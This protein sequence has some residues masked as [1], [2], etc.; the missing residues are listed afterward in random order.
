M[1]LWVYEEASKVDET[2]V[3]VSKNSPRTRDLCLKEGIEIIKTPGDGYVEDVRFILSEYGDFISSVADVPF[4]KASDFYELKK[5]F[6]GRSLTGVLP[7]SRIPKDLRPLTYKGYAIVGLN[8]VSWEGEEL[9]I[10]SNPLLALNVN[11]PKDLELARKIAKMIGR[12]DF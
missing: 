4:V 3:A 8:A 11:T 12:K 7:L 1:L 10:L 6:K 2:Y 9:F 5:A